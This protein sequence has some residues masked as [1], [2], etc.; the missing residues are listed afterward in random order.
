MRFMFHVFIDSKV[1][2]E[3]VDSF[4]ECFTDNCQCIIDKD[5]AE[6]FIEI[7]TSTDDRNY[8]YTEGE[9]LSTFTQEF[10]SQRISAS[11]INTL[12]EYVDETIL[13]KF[14]SLRRPFIVL[15]GGKNKTNYKELVEFVCFCVFKFFHID[16]LLEP[17]SFREIDDLVDMRKV[18]QKNFKVVTD[19]E[20]NQSYTKIKDRATVDAATIERSAGSDMFLVRRRFTDL[21]SEKLITRNLQ[22]AVT[23]CN[24]YAGYH[25]YN[26]EGK[27]IYESTKDRIVVNSNRSVVLPNETAIIRSGNGIRLKS[28]SGEFITINDGELVYI[29][30]RIGN[31][32]QILVSRNGKQYK[33]VVNS[34]VLASF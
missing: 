12:P 19:S 1:N 7:L 17:I 18:V 24:K 27:P 16:S 10:A 6:V 4:V 14:R 28:Q 13:E 9:I 8:L 26:E 21:G 5:S 30:K 33:T 20:G 29:S 25:V 22:K 32:A 3:M 31:E 23:E 11:I 34:D 2:E 15:L